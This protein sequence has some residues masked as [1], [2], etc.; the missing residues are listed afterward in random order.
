MRYYAVYLLLMNID[1][2]Q[3]TIGTGTQLYT[4]HETLAVV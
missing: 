3:C 1:I 4:K 2:G